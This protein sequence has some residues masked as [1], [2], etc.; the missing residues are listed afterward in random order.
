MQARATV[1]NNNSFG[2][3]INYL[4]FVSYHLVK[5][6]NGPTSFLK[7]NTDKSASKT[8]WSG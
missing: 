7:I 8:K 5:T 3:R 4:Q 2:F 1:I 6:Q